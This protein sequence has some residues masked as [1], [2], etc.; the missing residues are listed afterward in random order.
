[1][2]TGQISAEVGMRW[3]II[4]RS[5]FCTI[6]ALPRDFSPFYTYRMRLWR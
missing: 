1:M 2:E 3:L 6:Y 5:S 4:R